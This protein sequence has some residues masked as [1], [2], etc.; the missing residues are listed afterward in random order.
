MRTDK[1]SS[2]Y[3]RRVL[4]AVSG[5]IA[6]VKTPLLVS[7][8][9][10]AGAEVRCLVTPSGAAL[11]SPVALASLSR[12]RC[13]LEADQWNPK[14]TRPLHIELAEW[15]EVTIV[16]PLSASSMARWSQ[17]SADGLLASV[18]LATEGPV[19][20]A[21]AMNTAMWRHPAVQRNWLQIQDFP[22][23]VP[24]LPMSGLLACDRV[25]DGRMADPLLIELAAASL[26][27][28]SPGGPVANRDWSGM[29]VLV[30]AG[31]TQET[32]DAARFLSNRSSGRMGVL[33]AQAARFRGA[34]VQ[35]VHGPLD[36]PDAWLE[37][38]QCTPVESAAELSSALQLA[39]PT[40][41]VL[42]MAAAV[43]DLRREAAS[44]EKMPKKQLQDVLSSGWTEVPDLLSN[45][46]R[47]RRPGQLVLGFSALTGDDK[48]LLEKAE[49]KR[50]EKGCDLMMVNPVD[51]D[52][53]GFGNQPNGGWLLGEGW[54]R[55]L[56]VTTKL[57]LSHQ[58]LDAMFNLRDQAA[59]LV[60][61]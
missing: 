36:L 21:P 1:P 59:A 57:T 47:Q 38:L 40:S 11:V 46:T 48:H 19:I 8:L 51:R 34:T 16:A 43:A 3:G 27:S 15:A 60:D 54:N 53:Q 55:N 2:L 20:A 13:Y 24:L 4:V 45:M 14:A 12:H 30:S 61:S 56:P 23:I 37:G 6:A 42:V 9:V 33:L 44:E 49:R 35:L 28:R 39:L 10:K 7:A 5:S 18:L 32:I 50:L 26:F 29:S 41:D 17:G 31:P 58:L 25:G 52:G 22:G